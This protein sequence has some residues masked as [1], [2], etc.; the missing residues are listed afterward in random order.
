MME[1][2]KTIKFNIGGTKYEVSKALLE[3]YSGSMLETIASTRWRT[4]SS[5]NNDSIENSHEI[6]VDRNGER[7]QFVLDYMKDGVAVLPFSIPRAS[8]IQDLEYFGLDHVDS[9][10][11]I[12][13]PSFLELS[14]SLEHYH[15]CL[16]IKFH[17]ITPR[18]R[19]VVA[20]IMACD[21]AKE[22]F[23]KLL[24]T[25]Q[26]PTTIKVTVLHPPLCP[27]Q[28]LQLQKSDLQV[29]MIEFGLVIV[30][31]KYMYGFSKGKQ[32]QA[33]VRVELRMT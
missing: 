33:S 8:F 7:F 25:K 23:S 17:N 9:A 14:K 12:A 21:V 26:K 5:E 4:T 3:R 20:E 6:F 27:G 24:T 29:H 30:D 1:C 13:V 22:F 28:D 11:T 10:I 15:Y 16:E 32:D 19:A 18:Y 2:L 31:L